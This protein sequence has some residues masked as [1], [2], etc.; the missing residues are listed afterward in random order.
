MDFGFTDE[1]LALKTAAVEFAQGSLNEGLVERER[2]GDF[3]RLGWQRCAQFGV[4]GLPFPTELGGGGADIVTTSL[5]M[6][7]L[8]YGCQDNGLL[9]ALNAQMWSVQMPIWRSGSPEQQAKYLPRLCKG[10]LIG[11]HGMTEPESGSDAFSLR[12]RAE[13]VG[14]TYVLTGRKTFVTNAPIA[15][16]L[17]V[18]A[19]VNPA[20]GQLGIT[21]FLIDRGTPGLEV[22]RPLEKMG[23]RTS[24]MA[25]VSLDRCTV[26]ATARLGREGNGAAL[27][28]A[29]MA[30]ERACLL[31]T[32][33]GAMERQV[34]RCVKYAGQRHQFGQP[35]G[36]FQ[37]VAHKIA[38][39]KLRLEAARLLL[40]KVA[41]LKQQ[42]KPAEAEAAM[43]KILVS[44]A[45]VQSS[46]DAIQIHGGYGYMT[47]LEVERDLRDALAAKIYSGTSEI[48]RTIV[49]RS[50]GLF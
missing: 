6:E 38:D 40:Y 15:D 43:A 44:E 23:L 48:Q 5:V 42:G 45:W 31:A 3:S 10:E 24:P 18:F 33:L 28:S 49:A 26:P 14:E 50:L 39:M 25:E 17:L 21:A 22:G 11:A 46:Q 13:R 19:T 32:C 16:L 4:Q 20:M 2:A 30:W 29:S 37:A 41:W 1:Q 47:E 12:T 8:G 7:G 36:Q 27:F 34:E 35:I 9:F